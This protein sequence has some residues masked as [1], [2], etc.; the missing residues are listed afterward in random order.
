MLNRKLGI[1]RRIRQIREELYGENGI[2]VI[3][4][5][6]DVPVR[7]WLNFEQGVMMPADILLEF[8]VVAGLDPNWLLTGEGERLI[9]ADQPRGPEWI[10][11]TNLFEPR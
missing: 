8:L 7:T 10:R 9:G 3:A 6:L 11:L 5:T 4:K 2:E 1:A